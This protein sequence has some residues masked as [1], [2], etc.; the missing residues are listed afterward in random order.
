M[1]RI[2]FPIRL[3]QDYDPL[4]DVSVARRGLGSAVA[5]GTYRFE[6]KSPVEGELIVTP[7]APQSVLSTAALCRSALRLALRCYQNSTESRPVFP[8][9]LQREFA[10]CF[11]EDHEYLLEF[12]V[13]QA[14]FLV[15]SD[16]TYSL[17]LVSAN[18][19]AGQC[20]ASY[21]TLLGFELIL[22]L[23]HF[24]LLHALAGKTRRQALQATVCLYA[25][26]KPAEQ[27]SIQLVLR[28]PH[29]DS[30][31]LFSLFLQRASSP[32]PVSLQEIS[33][34]LQKVSAGHSVDL[35]ITWL[36]GQEKVDLPYSRQQALSILADDIA[37]DVKRARLYE[38][39]RDYDR[40]V[41][42]GNINRLA[43]EIRVAR[44]QLIFG[45]MSRA[46]HNQAGLF[47]DSLLLRP[48]PEWRVIADEL[49]QW[50][51]AN[52]TLQT[53]AGEL[54]L[55]LTGSAEVPLAQLEGACERFE[56]A[57]VDEQ[58]RLLLACLQEE[59][60]LARD[61]DGHVAERASGLDQGKLMALTMQRLQLAGRIRKTF[62]TAQ[63]R[64]A[65]FVVVSQRPSPTGS[66]LLIK[67]NELQ[68]PYLGKSENLLKLA[69]LSGDRLYSSPDY[70]WLEVADHWIEAI[71]LFIKEQVSI[72]NGV[73][74][75][76]TFVDIAAMEE[77]FREEM[78]DFW[79]RN[80]R[81]VLESE[82][83]AL[84][85]DCLGEP[86]LVEN[87]ADRLRQQ[88]SDAGKADDIAALGVLFGEAYRLGVADIHRLVEQDALGPSDALRR[89]LLNSELFR[90]ARENVQKGQ[91]S[92]YGASKKLLLDSAYPRD[93]ALELNRYRPN[94]LRPSRPLPVLHIL[95]TQSAGMTDG[96]IR[97]WLE[98][99]MALFNIADDLGLHEAVA[100]RQALFA[101][102]I[103]CL[104]GKVIRELGIWVEVEEL[105]G[106][107]QLSEAQAIHQIIRRNRLVQEELSNLGVLIEYEEMATGLRVEDCALEPLG[108][109]ASWAML[110]LPHQEWVLDQVCQRN[111]DILNAAIKTD[112]VLQPKSTA[113]VDAMREIVLSYEAC[114]EDISAYTLF[115]ARR[116]AL[117][118]LVTAHPGLFLQELGKSYYRRYHILAKTTARKQIIAERGLNHLSLHPLY[119]FQASGGSK[120]YHL[121]YTPSRVDLGQR[122]R[123]S[124]ES[125]SQ[126]VGGADAA[127]ARV[128]RDFYSLI[129]KDVRVFESLAE[130]ETLKTG[131]NAS[132]TS[133]F[134]FSNAL[135]LMVASA[136]HGDFETMGD[137]MNARKDRLI[138]P[139]GE[140]YGGYCVPKDGL[141]LEFVLSLGRRE[142]LSQI[143]LPEALHG[144]VAELAQR[145]LDCRHQF[146]TTLEWQAWA[147]L[148]LE[149]EGLGAG[150]DSSDLTP[151][152]QVF[153]TTR[154]AHVLDRLGQPELRDPYR[155]MCGM[156]ARWGLHKMVTGG[157]QVNRFMPFYKVWL[158]RQGIIESARRNADPH[159]SPENAV[160]V[161]TAEYKPD[162]QD[163]RFAVGMRKF[164]ILVGSGG[165]LAQAL[166]MEG[167]DLALLMG[168]GFA[169]LEKRGRHHSLLPWLVEGYGS[170]SHLEKLRTLFPG[171]CAPAEIRIVSTTGLVAQDLLNY[172]GDTQLEQIACGVRNELESLGVSG[173]EIDANLK[174]W[175]PR[176]LDW[177]VKVKLGTDDRLALQ[178]RLGGP[179]HALALQVAGPERSFASA[180]SGADVLDTGIPHRSLLEL[181]GSP[182]RL[183]RLMLKGNPHSALAIVDG[184]SG[185]RHRAMNRMDVM[186]WFAAGD[187]MGRQSV[188]LAIG[189]GSET[190]EGWRADMRAQRSSA[191]ALF[192]AV[193]DKDSLVANRVYAGIVEDLRKSQ[194]A[195]A[196]LAELDK[197]RRFGRDRE[198]DS[199]ISRCL[200]RISC[201]VRLAELGFSDF[202]S[203]GGIFLLNGAGPKEIQAAV[204]T[205]CDGIAHL[206]GRP[207]REDYSFAAL[208]EEEEVF[209]GNE[210]RQ[211]QGFES[212]N[213]ATEDR[214]AVA[215]QTRQRLSN[216]IA[217]ARSL[218]ARRAAFLTVK[219]DAGCDFEES[220]HK[221]L[222]ALGFDLRPIGEPAFGAFLGH[223]R[224]A[225]RQLIL[226]QA[227]YQNEAN[228]F[229]GLVD[230]LIT[231]NKT[232]LKLWD[233]IAGGYEDIG[234]F[235]RLAQHVAGEA[236]LGIVQP[237]SKLKRLRRIAAG[238]EL[239]YI[240]LAVECTLPF[241]A[242]NS[243]D[244]D[245]L[246]L[247]RALADFFAKTINDHSYEYRPWA[248][249]RGIGFSDFKG[250]SLYELAFEHHQWLYRY[251]R[252]VITGF[253]E[254]AGLS[255]AEQQLLL[256]NFLDGVSIEAIGGEAE[257]KAERAWRAYGQLR[258]LAFIRNDGFALP[259]VFAEFDP[260]WIQAGQRVNHI[261][262][263]PVGRT[264]FS[265]CL[266]EGP[267]LA[268]QLEGEARLGANLIITRKV[269]VHDSPD[270]PRPVMCIHSGHL[271]IDSTAY[272]TA[273][274][275]GKGYTAEA[276]AELAARLH[277]KG[278]RIAARFVRPVLAAL[279]YP[280]HGD[281]VYEAGELEQC[282][283]PFTV[284]SRFHTWTSYD[285]SKYPEL[286]KDSGV[287]M[288][289][290]MD[291]L[292]SYTVQIAKEAVCKE[293]I[294]DG[295]NGT[296][297]MGLL[298]FAGLHP[299]VMVK[300]AAES[301]GRGAQAFQ[302]RSA[303]G[304]TDLAEIDRAT[305]FI[306]Q[307]SLR[308]NV[309]IQ[310]VVRS[311]PEHW[312]TEAFM[313]NFTHRQ[314]VEW[315]SPVNRRRE[316][317]TPVYGSHRIIM[318]TDSPAETDALKKWHVSHWITLN[319]KQ[320]ITNIG[321]G[322][323]LDLLR[324]ETIRPEHRDAILAKLADAGRKVMQALGAYEKRAAVAYEQET[325]RKIGTDLLN[326]SYGN[327]RYMMLDFLITPVF[328]ETGQLV[329]VQ[330]ETNPESGQDG[331]VFILQD[332]VH[333]FTGR[334]IDWRV[335]LI[336]PNIGVGLWDRVALREEFSEIE[337]AQAEG[338]GPD[339]DRIGENARIVLRD[340]H[341]AGEEYLQALQHSQHQRVTW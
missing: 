188:Y 78:A 121:L 42:Q 38:L 309:A 152:L 254:V 175:G 219:S 178:Q 340:L 220:Y 11:L 53:F 39:L 177:D 299:L 141:F 202:L 35:Q 74:S 239:F 195:P 123:E 15:A 184:A 114:R 338:R 4:S 282:G 323:T 228:G 224:N 179:L 94:A 187:F 125:W 269:W 5:E 134:G 165:F 244:S 186:L 294:R 287:D 291:W 93:F 216:R 304:Q 161:V 232:D 318:S 142:K 281:P 319:S 180:L 111:A 145:L 102:R 163:S 101:G 209:A 267:T 181:L 30:G 201:G 148:Q 127:A 235:G 284:Q 337:Q 260:D 130:P 153:Q 290:E 91:D 156:A 310:E 211:E 191:T 14:R 307:L 312:A 248:Y 10:V 171:Y 73:E 8:E 265:R 95:T 249:S 295:L 92:W 68:E 81:N 331:V 215:L 83:I 164:E 167:Q 54:Q 129:N 45:R 262:A 58:K 87:D 57:V 22:S 66:H 266:R 33:A 204:E 56:E 278:L 100:K 270:Y 316:P 154:L 332:G 72:E 308:H 65:A 21:E 230:Q 26:F 110:D 84:A 9:V 77:S 197:L 321:R 124:V 97:T 1:H 289:V 61:R 89:I 238:A 258:E 172:T 69:R 46:F 126:W 317:K 75:S 139:A 196:A 257:G 105:S 276:A 168:D 233:K 255:P 293:C 273:L 250:E 217:Q 82:W 71:P 240:L 206:G 170:A 285:K 63:T 189:L 29:L 17:G 143:G 263:A 55:L 27:N 198:R 88:P 236:D 315:G 329:E 292:A 339:W 243:A 297:Y 242:T 272:Q 62:A 59:R 264:H 7:N 231:G 52:P 135:A 149:S 212:S 159:I 313:R 234:E 118:R 138:H 108:L 112:S 3:I 2:C 157:E 44:Q 341:R 237:A 190:V 41:E 31:N 223:A 144:P 200:A 274:V 147:A 13:G 116:Q 117:S 218:N 104:G 120:R 182:A 280:F 155:L 327:P 98:E 119:Y 37:T 256:G 12:D 259:E 169:E 40:V 160:I 28:S 113:E 229:L 302:F 47:A 86:L 210:F 208:L 194:A 23:G 16:I 36:F 99:S 334:V 245:S 103:L 222:E 271:T 325:G 326:V 106:C 288:P 275:S 131:E 173:K 24:F 279:V 328:A 162:T 227:N 19:Q 298:A 133:H 146:D 137:N 96:Y 25:S 70:A 311:S 306:Y 286:F 76:K 132:M 34:G 109:Q 67:I 185:A 90:Q 283:L 60:R 205:Y 18:L 176:L 213:K 183:C 151:A 330:T 166:D 122:E 51:D 203:L 50:V 115:A 246:P 199:I 261:I 79:A 300:D 336:E 253:T 6:G 322:G 48:M 324:P 251:L 226:E 128:G 49:P 214:P 85:Q 296:P 20:V 335:V 252:W 174:S 207:L 225:L 150:F 192:R 301:G 247:W 32:A 241:T 64:P 80:I 193:A 268:R 333:R 136:Q 107:G 277:S 158:I 303:C 43:T 305:D 314:I 221:A 320:L 140:G